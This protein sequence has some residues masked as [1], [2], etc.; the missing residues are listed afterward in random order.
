[1][2]IVRIEEIFIKRFVGMNG[3]LVTFYFSVINLFIVIFLV[4]LSYLDIFEFSIFLIPVFCIFL[5]I[6]QTRFIL[7]SFSLIELGDHRNLAQSKWQRTWLAAVTLISTIFNLINILGYIS[8]ILY[9]FNLIKIEGRNFPN[10]RSAIVSNILDT[11]QY[12]FGLC[13]IGISL[14]SLIYMAKFLIIA[15][16]IPLIIGII[17]MAQDKTNK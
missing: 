15:F 10:A 17:L 11:N 12:I 1:M 4:L 9:Y 8:E 6:F 7:F 2:D 16:A 13:Q 3:D 14:V 5:L